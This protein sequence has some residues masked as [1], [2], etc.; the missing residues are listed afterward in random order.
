[1]VDSITVQ[2]IPGGRFIAIT[3]NDNSNII[4]YSYEILDSSSG[5]VG[6]GTTPSNNILSN[7]ILAAGASWDTPFTYTIDANC[8]ESTCTITG[9]IN[10]D[11][12]T[13]EVVSWTQN[14]V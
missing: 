4:S 10:V 5:D 3:L 1:V 14:E 11:T 7:L 8:A 13:N 6:T 12:A 9:V 2:V